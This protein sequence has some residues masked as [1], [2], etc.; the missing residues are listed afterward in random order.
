MEDSGCSTCASEG[1]TSVEDTLQNTMLSVASGQHSDLLSTSATQ[2]TSAEQSSEPSE[3]PPTLKL[4]EDS[5][6][7]YSNG[8]L[9][10]DGSDSR[11]EG[12]WAAEMDGDH[13][14]GKGCVKLPTK[15]GEQ[16]FHGQ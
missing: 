7:P 14:G 10:E 6:V 5:K 11:H 1:G 16:T 2:D 9:K 13:S 15:H 3:K 4:P 12:N 8:M